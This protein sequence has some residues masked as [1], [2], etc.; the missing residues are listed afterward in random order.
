MMPEQQ[1]ETAKRAKAGSEVEA[2][3][4]KP[5]TDDAAP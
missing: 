3:A 4:E 5:E 1:S 2:P